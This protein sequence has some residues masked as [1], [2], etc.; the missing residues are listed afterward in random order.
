VFS[1]VKTVPT[2]FKDAPIFLKSVDPIE[3]IEYS[4]PG[5][6]FPDDT[7]ALVPGGFPKFQPDGLVHTFNDIIALSC[8][9]IYR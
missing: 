4:N 5:T 2:A 3:T 7:A 1:A 9:N 8:S 6:K